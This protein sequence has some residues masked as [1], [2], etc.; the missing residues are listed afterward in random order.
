MGGID[1]DKG[2]G[3]ISGIHWLK[4]PD[5]SNFDFFSNLMKSVRYGDRT[6][7][8]AIALRASSPQY[9]EAFVFPFLFLFLSS[10]SRSHLERVV[11][12]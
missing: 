6:N 5:R 3:H 7:F 11:R 12:F 1:A 2:R 8:M 4:T 9:G 10:P